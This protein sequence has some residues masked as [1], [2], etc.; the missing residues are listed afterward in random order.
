[1]KKALTILLLTLI[2]ITLYACGDA[3]TASDTDDS[4]L[5]VSVSFNALYE[6]A[7]AVGG[8]NVEITTIIPNG[9]EP[10]DFEPKVTDIKSL[11]NAQVFIY[12]GL[13]MEP[14]AEASIVSSENE[15]LISVIASDSIQAISNTGEEEI[16]EH[17]QYDP[18]VWISISGAKVEVQ[19][20]ANAFAEADPSN[21]EFYQ[22]NATDYI[23]SLDDIYNEYYEK[24]QSLENNHFVTS[25]AAFQYFCN[26][27]GL[28][29]NSV[30]DVFAEGEPSLKQLTDLV[31]YCRE[32]NVTTIFSEELGN[33]EISTTLASEVGGKI[34]TIYTMESAED[35]LSY[36]ERMRSNCKKVYNSLAE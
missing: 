11:A 18:H 9:S 26:D 17:G 6:F 1:M 13:D 21:S 7:L 22:S 12:N 2:S 33:A 8:D 19:N 5:Q 15:D 34:E 14:W 32:N 31:D 30:E 36:L 10:H 27:F 16:E 29:Q 20:I 28:E 24:F 23:Q 35:N 4:K 25:H 3:S